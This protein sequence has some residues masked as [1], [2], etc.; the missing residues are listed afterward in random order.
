MRQRL[1]RL[2]KETWEVASGRK[3]ILRME[4]F[5][6]GAAELLWFLDGRSSGRRDTGKMAFEA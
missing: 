1:I 2:E 6:A 3:G 5:P 4:I